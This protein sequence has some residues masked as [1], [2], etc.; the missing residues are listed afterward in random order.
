MCPPFLCLL[1]FKNDLSFTH[2]VDKSL[3]E[4]MDPFLLNIF[5]EDYPSDVP[6]ICF[7]FALAAKAPTLQTVKVEHIT[8]NMGKSYI[9]YDIWCSGLSPDIFFPISRDKQDVWHSLLQCSYGWQDVYSGDRVPK[10][11]RRSMNPGVALDRDHWS[12]W[13]KDDF[14]A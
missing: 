12:E 5:D 14:F 13:H 11:L 6:I 3:F 1:Q 4:C 10:R 9:M 7:I 8:I 2:Q